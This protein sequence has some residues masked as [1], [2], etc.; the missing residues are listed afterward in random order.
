MKNSE[1]EDSLSDISN[2]EIK[3]IIKKN[4]W[5]FGNTK[6]IV[7]QILFSKKKK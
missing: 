7:K 3:N 1:A 2:E 5:K 4:G 6:Q